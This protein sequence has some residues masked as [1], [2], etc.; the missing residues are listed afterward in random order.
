MNKISPVSRSKNEAR[1][2]YNNIS[3]IYDWLTA[4]EEEFIRK[5]VDLLQVSPGQ[6]ILEVGCGTGRA[7][8]MMGKNLSHSGSLVGVDLSH[9][10]LQKS[11]KKTSSQTTPA[12]HLIQADGANLPLKDNL[13]DGVFISFTLEL[14]T[15]EEIRAVLDQVKRVLV[16]EGK[17]IVIALSKEP[18]NLA[19][20]LY[21]AAH[22]LFPVA[23]DCRPIPLVDLMIENGFSIRETK[24]WMNWGLPID[25]AL[26]TLKR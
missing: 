24:K 12:P 1:K 18:E 21:E 23:L 13:F 3:G 6:K 14:F 4:S 9:Q 10:M 11:R 17:L 26:C 7:L 25:I 15:L 16:P 20:K 8:V 22:Q 19:V 2:Y 5:G